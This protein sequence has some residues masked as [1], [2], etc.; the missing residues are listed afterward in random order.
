M[1]KENKKENQKIVPDTSILIQGKL[2]ALIE[3]GELKDVDIIIPEM[4]LDELQ[5]QASRG[6]DIGFEGL[7]EIKKIREIGKDKGIKIEFTG[8]RPTQEEINLAKKGRID[9]LIRDAA[10]THGAVLYT[11]DY[12]QALTGEVEGV[13]IK[14]IPQP[15]RVSELILENFFTE[16]TQ[17]VHLKEG[18]SPLAKKGKPGQISLVKIREEPVSEE[19]INDIINQV[20]LKA[21]SD[22]DSNIEMG[23]YGAM[24]IQLRNYRIAITKPPFSD[25][26]EVTA[27][28]PT[29]KVNLESYKLHKDIEKRIIENAAGVLIAGPPGSG[30][31][32]FA[33]SISDFISA[34]NKI[35]KTFEQ[36]RD[37]QVGKEVT[38]YA[39]LEGSWEKTSEILLLVRPDYTIF[40]EIRKTQDF[41]VFADMRLAGVGMVGVMHATDPINAIQ[42]FIGRI[43]LG[44]IPHVIDIVIYIKDGQIKKVLELSMSVKVPS[45]MVEADLARPVVE[46]RDFETKTLEFEIYSYGEENVVMPVK[47]DSKESGVKELAKN[48]VYRE[49][50]RFDR[51]AK[52]SILSDDRV[53]VKVRNEAIPALIGKKG[54]NIEALEKKLGISITVEPKDETFKKEVEYGMEE[55]GA[56]FVIFVDQRYTGKMVDLYSGDDFILS[57]TVGKKGKISINKKSDV[58]SAVLQALTVNKLRVLV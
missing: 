34:K 27:V 50:S 58:G 18:I 2:S 39:P 54:S 41:R 47:E 45:G 35:V 49:V 28:R 57:S 19:E 8:R 44:T 4:A 51:D 6:K 42:R 29:T 12:V 26:V 32:T 40:D 14:Y 53:L 9:A 52:I 7:E 25:A 17:S 11:S 48:A 5:A 3:S 38:Q 37:L 56:H 46:V 10:K 13:Q 31:S 21:R 36:P 33:A 55:S 23:L 16:D 24:V 1:T 15:L 43:E 30:K 22:K 20:V